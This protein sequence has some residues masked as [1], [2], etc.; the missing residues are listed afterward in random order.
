MH[1]FS[2]KNVDFCRQYS[3]GDCQIIMTLAVGQCHIYLLTCLMQ[4]SDQVDNV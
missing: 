1:Q 4:V 2:Q 3:P